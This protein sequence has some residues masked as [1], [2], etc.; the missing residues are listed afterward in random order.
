M[1]TEQADADVPAQSGWRWWFGC[2][3][4]G[5]GA[6]LKTREKREA[7]MSVPSVAWQS[8]RFHG[9]YTLRSELSDAVVVGSGAPVLEQGEMQLGKGGRGLLGTV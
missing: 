2:S 8:V 7:V 4:L 6:D 3:C 5:A 1:A 9:M